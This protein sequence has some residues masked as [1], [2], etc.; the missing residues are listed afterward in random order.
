MSNDLLP[1]SSNKTIND[2]TIDREL[3]KSQFG[4]FFQATDNTTKESVCINILSK[5]HLISARKTENLLNEIRV[6][7]SSSNPYILPLLYSFEDSENVFLV[8]SFQTNGSL[9]QILGNI[10]TIDIPCVKYIS[11][12]L[13]LALSDLHKKGIIHRDLKPSNILFDKGFGIKIT[14]FSQCAIFESPSEMPSELDFAGTADYISPETISGDLIGPETD[15]WSLGIVIYQ[16][17]A[18]S[19]PFQANYPYQTLQLISEGLNQKT[20]PSFLPEDFKNLILGLL[21]SDPN[22]RLGHGEF[23]QGYPSIKNHAFF[24]GFDFKNI[25]PPP[26]NEWIPFVPAM[27]VLYPEHKT[28]RKMT[29]RPESDMKEIENPIS[30]NLLFQGEKALFEGTIQKRVGLSSKERILVLTNRPR[31][32]YFDPESKEIKGEINL[33]KELKVTIGSKNKWTIDVPGRTY[34]LVTK[35]DPKK[36]KEVLEKIISLF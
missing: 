7:S 30:K 34:N 35:D 12:T 24:K 3:G 11:A 1:H 2:F 17:L 15:L 25:S 5:E 27:K 14:G 6:T 36:W 4:K 29:E 32:F 16:L 9:K 19:P 21:N 33:C 26:V 31:L 10:K 8:T 20:I 13:L 28:V 23:N 18:N 22:N